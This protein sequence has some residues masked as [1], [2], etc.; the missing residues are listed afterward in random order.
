MRTEKNLLCLV[1]AFITAVLLCI[2]A[3]AKDYTPDVGST[4]SFTV[5]YTGGTAEN[6]YSLV[7][8]EGDYTGIGTLPELSSENIIYIDQATAD[9]KGFVEF[10]SF[11][12]LRETV[13]TIYLGGTDLDSP[14]I[15]GRLTYEKTEFVFDVNNVVI[16]Y[17]GN[18]G[19]IIL[20]QGT[21]SIDAN[22]FAEKNVT[23]MKV[24]SSAIELFESVDG[25]DYYYSYEAAVDF[26]GVTLGKTCYIIGDFD[27]NGVVNEKDLQTFLK[28]KA[29]NTDVT[30]NELQGDIDLDGKTLL[31]D[32][33]ALMKL[34]LGNKSMVK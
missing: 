27:N 3:E 2:F 19:D 34:L 25:I 30:F 20:P 8:V 29:G 23:S 14:V 31:N 16:E 18:G 7:A 11:S 5:T 10:K 15:L 24:P 6:F 33:A 12:P 9:E 4:D 22:A 32:I 21:A 28:A 26:S 1:F 17:N 13:G